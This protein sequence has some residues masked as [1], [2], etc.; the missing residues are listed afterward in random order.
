[1]IRAVNI[2]EAATGAAVGAAVGAAAVGVVGE[3]AVGAAVG[4]AAAGVVG[5]VSTT[6]TARQPTQLQCWLCPPGNLV[7]ESLLCTTLSP[8]MWIRM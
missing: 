1:M 7:R 3:A 4:G 8:H 5:F 2:S 6:P